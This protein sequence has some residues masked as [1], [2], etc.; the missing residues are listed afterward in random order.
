M[1]FKCS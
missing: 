1:I